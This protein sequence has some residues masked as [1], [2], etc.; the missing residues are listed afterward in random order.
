V[1]IVLIR[2][3][4]PQVEPGTCYGRLDLPLSLEGEALI[5][6]MLGHPEL[7]G[8]ARIWSSPARRCR[9]VAEPISI[10]LDVAVTYDARLA[11]RDFGDWEGMPWSSIDR[12]ELDRWAAAPTSFRPPN[13]ESG[14][15][16]VERVRAVHRNVEQRGESVIVI[17]HGG[18]LRVLAALLRRDA[19]DLLAPPLALGTIEVVR[20]PLPGA[21]QRAERAQ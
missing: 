13:G 12:K 17:S 2:H 7:E 11:E 3:P 1:K 8:S 16:L 6:R 5:P 4:P 21:N 9:A 14:E 15:T 20:V 10:Y 18:P 19:I